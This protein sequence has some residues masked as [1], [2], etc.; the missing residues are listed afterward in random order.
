M[1]TKWSGI[2]LVT[3]LL[4]VAAV[5]T[6]LAGCGSSSATSATT[7]SSAAASTGSAS[8]DASS[9]GASAVSQAQS[10]A[11]KAESAPAQIP[12]TTPL[13]SKPPT[14]KLIIYIDNEL[15]ASV[16][17]EKAEAA[18]AKAVGW[19]FENIAYDAANPATLVAGLQTALQK[20]PAAVMVTGSPPSTYGAST[21]KAYKQARIP[22]VVGA[23]YP[24]S[25]TSTL[26]GDPNSGAS[27]EAGGKAVADWF[28]AD[29]AGKGKAILA[30]VTA[31]PIYNAFNKG[32]ED[33][34]NSLC[35]GCTY[36]TFDISAADVNANQSVPLAVSQMR[37]NPSYKY[38]F[39]DNGEYADG[40]GPALS[41][42]GLSGIKVGG[43]SIDQDG[44]AYL[45]SNGGAWTGTNY[46]W[47]GYSLVD[48]ALR[49]VEG[50][51]I[52][53]ADNDALSQLITSSNVGSI[54][55]PY[56]T[57]TDALSQFEKLWHV[58]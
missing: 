25:P 43:R 54:T 39:F 44:A 58:G 18:A 11:T 13:P 26:L 28:I 50:A 14:G 36:K 9:S 22:I 7:S 30:T 3:G 33:E 17:I 23:V 8:S 2:R 51:P 12:Q 1:K 27:E 35:P 56:V 24:F 48:V 57:P 49:H 19:S 10:L 20:K 38:L 15:A 47:L 40:I 41:T 6:A 53:A 32:F 55:L 4:V 21:L 46:N 42:A 45:K 34:V 29:S 5:A 16:E 31:Y 37:T 52:P